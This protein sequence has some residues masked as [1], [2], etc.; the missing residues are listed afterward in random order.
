MN[1]FDGNKVQIRLRLQRFCIDQSADASSR[2][3]CS[4]TLQAHQQQSARVAACL[5]KPKSPQSSA[6]S[7]SSHAAL[8]L[9]QVHCALADAGAAG[10]VA[11]EHRGLRP[12]ALVS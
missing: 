12:R 1:C 7:P 2:L 9:P 10:A 6:Q 11:S 3:I 8:L 5:K 4:A